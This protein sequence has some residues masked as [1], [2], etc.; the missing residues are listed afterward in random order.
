MQTF[1][2]F[3]IGSLSGMIATS[4][5]QPIDTVKVVIQSKGESAGKNRTGI[6]PLA[7]GK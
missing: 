2:P 4:V 1:K 3:A 7:V 5:I 6:T